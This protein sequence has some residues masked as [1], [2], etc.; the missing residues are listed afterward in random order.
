[1]EKLNT[2]TYSTN[3]KKRNQ[4]SLCPVCYETTKDKVKCVK[5]HND[6]CKRCI[7]RI[8]KCPMCRATPFKTFSYEHIL[9]IIRQLAYIMMIKQIIKINN[10]KE[11]EY[12]EFSCFLCNYKGH[13]NDFKAHLIKNHKKTV[14]DVF[15]KK[16]NND[17]K[18]SIVGKMINELYM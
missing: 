12:Y 6:F 13:R 8:D 7:F 18:K 4:N 10:I 5:C 17:R 1:M 11:N 3:N 14:L 16:I 2:I 9:K 15:N